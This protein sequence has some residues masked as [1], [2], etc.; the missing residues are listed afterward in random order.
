MLL[1]EN[2]QPPEGDHRS[3]FLKNTGCERRPAIRSMEIYI[4]KPYTLRKVGFA[5][6]EELDK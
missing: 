1:Q 4:E 5:V 6:K 2:N 3:G